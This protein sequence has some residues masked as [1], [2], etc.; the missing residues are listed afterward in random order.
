M[1]MDKRKASLATKVIALIVALAFVSSM[2]IWIVPYL[3]QEETSPA[4]GE[5]QRYY[6]EAVYRLE[7]VLGK[8]PKN[9]PALIELGNLHF[10]YRNY[11][12]AIAA[13]Q[14][15][16]ELDPDN[17]DVRT[18]MGIAYFYSGDPDRAI[19]E[20]NTVIEANPQHAIAYLNL[21]VVYAETGRKEE[22]IKAWE[23]Y[24]EL[25]PE[26][27]YADFVKEELAKVKKAGE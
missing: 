7:Q 24:L 4:N 17:G 13:Y 1:L 8:D 23:K 20:F 22:A 21:G 2:V 27:A 26:G 6:E 3:R 18:D 15:A 10:D 14:K 25:E 19:G 11:P 16:L 9:L 12:Q 5:A